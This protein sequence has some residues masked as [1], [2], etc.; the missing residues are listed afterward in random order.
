M[1][2]TV[3]LLAFFA[4]FSAIS[5][6][7]IL[8][9]TRNFLTG[10]YYYDGYGRRRYDAYYPDRYVRPRYYEVYE[11]TVIKPAIIQPSIVNTTAAVTNNT[12]ISE[13]DYQFVATVTL[14]GYDKNDI[15]VSALDNAIQ[16]IANPSQQANVQTGSLVVA[17]FKQIIPVGFII[18]PE[19]VSSN[20][21][22]GVLTIKVPKYT[23]SPNQ[24]II[25]PVQ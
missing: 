14:P 21:M 24:K 4:V 5:L 16:I 11:P 25:I 8:D 23:A 15:Q 18:K 6:N 20:Y 1:K 10:R 19:E 2:K 17:P 3:I 7:A 9:R 22:N 13:D 12:I